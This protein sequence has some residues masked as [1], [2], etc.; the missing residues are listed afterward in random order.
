MPTHLHRPVPRL[1]VMPLA[2]SN[3]SPVLPLTT[4]LRMN[5]LCMYARSLA[6]YR[7]VGRQC[8]QGRSL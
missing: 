5:M 8:P 3:H 7:K 4:R 2:L 1:L 6:T